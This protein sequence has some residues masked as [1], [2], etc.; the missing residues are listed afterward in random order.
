MAFAILR[1]E[2]LKSAGSIGGSLAHSFRTRETK[3]ADPGGRPRNEFSHDSPAVIQ[4]AIQERLPD[5]RRKDAVLALE[6]FVGASPEWFQRQR[7]GLDEKYF[8]AARSWLEAR[9]GK[10]NVVGWVVHR[11]ELTPHMAI[12]VVPRDGD[13]LNAKKWTGGRKALS[14][15]QTDF[16][17][18]VGK[19]FGLERGIEG[20]IAKH[21]E[22]KKFYHL[23][24]SATPKLPL[25]RTPAPAR[26][27]TIS[28]LQKLLPAD[29]AERKRQEEERQRQIQ[30]RQREIEERARAM[31]LLVEQ[32]SAKAVALDSALQTQKAAIRIA[33]EKIKLA[34][35][36]DRLKDEL[37]ETKSQLMSTKDEL[38]KTQQAYM[39]AHRELHLTK[40]DLTETREALEE[41]RQ[42]NSPKPAPDRP[43]G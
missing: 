39:A 23:V 29:R 25:I 4:A 28:V 41:E 19:R 18:A 37:D 21:E 17:Q 12:Y 34:R 27:P 10:E 22:V 36:A 8:A 32:L 24:N 7:P 38:Q 6:F 20:S 3:N 1:V 11:D 15:M 30:Q 42:K 43:R 35:E 14:Q 9:H 31:D 33:Q 5:R 40:K 16:A 13:R 26:L 2:K